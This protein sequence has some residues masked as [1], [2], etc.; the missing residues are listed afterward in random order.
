MAIKT[1]TD[2][3]PLT[4]THCFSELA[5]IAC[6]AKHFS[7]AEDHLVE[8]STE[9]KSV[10]VPND[11][12]IDPD[13]EEAALDLMLA[14]LKLVVAT[15]KTKDEWTRYD[16]FLCLSLHYLASN[17]ATLRRQIVELR[18]THATAQRHHFLIHLK[19]IGAAA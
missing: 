16:S 7:P 1:K 14:S 17:E 6:A 19:K 4:L 13:A 18:L 12:S 10:C 11:L 2:A 3:A 15:L 8:V 5:N 9:I